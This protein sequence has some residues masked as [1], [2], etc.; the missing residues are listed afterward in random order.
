MPN[1]PDAI[2][3]P[4]WLCDLVRRRFRGVAAGH[5]LS[6]GGPFLVVEG[7]DG[8]GKTTLVDN[9]LAKQSSVD[10][11]TPILIRL[12]QRE[13]IPEA[14]RPVYQAHILTVVAAAKGFPEAC[15]HLQRIAEMDALLYKFR[16]DSARRHSP[17]MPMISDSWAHKRLCKFLALAMASGQADA[18][19]LAS[20]IID[21]YAP[22]TGTP[23]GVLVDVPPETA[24]ERKGGRFSPWE[25]VAPPGLAHLAPADRFLQL[26]RATATLL[27]VMAESMGWARINTAR[28]RVADDPAHLTTLQREMSAC[29][30]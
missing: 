21:A 10:E 20:G 24:L 5:R 11:P 25:T 18:P 30:C 22:V 16:L 4:P 12:G 7:I 9:L 17:D 19:G 27:S 23:S 8:A 29:H 1:S 26:A 2:P 3:V 15:A 6:A 14:I 13:A 28:T